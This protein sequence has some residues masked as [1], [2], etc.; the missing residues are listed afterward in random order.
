MQENPC[1][2]L[3][4]INKFGNFEPTEPLN[5][6]FVLVVNFNDLNKYFLPLPWYEVN[7]F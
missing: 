3:N 2:R 4:I 5:W 1:K 7:E 6:N